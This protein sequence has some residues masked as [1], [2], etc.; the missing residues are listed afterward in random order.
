MKIDQINELDCAKVGSNLRKRFLNYT[1]VSWV[2]ELQK[3]NL[4]WINCDLA[5]FV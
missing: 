2:T 1:G 3:D 4:T 5:I